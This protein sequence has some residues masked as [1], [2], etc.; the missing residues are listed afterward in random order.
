[1]DFVRGIPMM[2]LLL[3]MDFVGVPL[4]IDVFK[5]FGFGLV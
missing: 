4:L 2:V 5:A 3:Y 1:L